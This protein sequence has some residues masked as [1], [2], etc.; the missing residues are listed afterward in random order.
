LYPRA[1]GFYL[2]WG[3][4]SWPVVSTVSPYPQGRH[5][6]VWANGITRLGRDGFNNDI[7]AADGS[8]ETVAFG[9]RDMNGTTDYFSVSVRAFSDTG[10]AIPT[11][12]LNTR[13][14]TAVRMN[15]T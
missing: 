11:L 14:I 2:V 10:A 13:S 5:V 9:G 15:T 8:A 3:S 1:E 12:R 6:E 7:P 4:L